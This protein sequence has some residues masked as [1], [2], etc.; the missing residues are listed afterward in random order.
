MF[1][2]IYQITRKNIDFIS[3]KD[4]RVVLD[5]RFAELDKV[6]LANAN[7]ST[8]ILSIS[9]IEGI[10]KHLANI[11]K[12]QIKNSP[13]YPKNEKGDKKK[14]SKLTIE[15]IYK[16]ILERDILQEIENF[17]NIYKIFRKYR[18]FIHPIKHKR[19]LWPVGLGQAQMAIGLLNA[20]LDQIAKHIFIEAEIFE[21][22]SGRPRFDLSRQ[23]NLEM[24]KNIP[25]NSFMVSK[26]EINAKFN[27]NCNVELGEDGVF[28]FIFNCVD[29]SNFKML[30]I[31]SRKGE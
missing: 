30:R 3:D 24:I 1:E 17:D 6:F 19:D 21:R 23:L 7:L 25:T 4:L 14:F 13:D 10:F 20:T 29:E 31:D 28:N 15:E 18:N 12:K 8:I 5:E 27:L 9:S 16:L 26:R 11:F 2:N 22:I